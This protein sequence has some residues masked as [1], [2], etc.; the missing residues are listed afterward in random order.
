MLASINILIGN[1]LKVQRLKLNYTLKYVSIKTSLP[2]SKICKIE[3]GQQLPCIKTLLLLCKIY[4]IKAGKLLLDIEYIIYPP[5][6]DINST[7]CY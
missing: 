4:N 6:Q 7:N 2:E 1:S 3:N 5:P